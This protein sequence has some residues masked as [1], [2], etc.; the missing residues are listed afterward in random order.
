MFFQSIPVKSLK[1]RFKFFGHFVL[2]F[3]GRPSFCYTL[4]IHPCCRMYT[5]ILVLNIDFIF[6]LSLSYIQGERI[7]MPAGMTNLNIRIDKKTKESAESIFDEMG[8]TMTSAITMFLRQTVRDR[9]FPFTADLNSFGP[10]TMMAIEEGRRIAR[11]SS[12]QGFSD[13][14]DLRAALEE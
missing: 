5:N 3:S 6:T 4:A 8:L 10:E 12:V 9:R 14:E 13:I 7:M 11:D 1:C 2:S